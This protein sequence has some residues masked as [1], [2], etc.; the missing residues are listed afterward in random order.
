M[1]KNDPAMPSDFSIFGTF[2]DNG[3]FGALGALKMAVNAAGDIDAARAEVDQDLSF[4]NDSGAGV[5]IYRLREGIERFF[6]SDINNAAATNK[7]QSEIAVQFDTISTDVSFYSHIP[8]GANVL[9]MDGHVEFLKYPS[10]HPASRA[11]AG[12]MSVFASV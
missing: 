9:F 12:L 2:I 5:T 6:I 8:G 7:A 3:F 4:T 1:D 10:D 11:W